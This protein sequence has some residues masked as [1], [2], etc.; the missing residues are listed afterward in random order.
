MDPAF[1]LA[2]QQS[3]V[4]VP[5]SDGFLD[6][7]VAESL[8]VPARVWQQMLR[9]LL[10]EDHSDRLRDIAVPS[11]IIWGDQDAFT[12]RSEQHLLLNLIPEARLSIYPGIGHAPHWEDT[13]R[14]SADIAAFI[15]GE[16]ALAA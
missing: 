9:A 13:P 11:L 1:A 8:K 3:S 16:N 4:A 6:N 5:L 2:F 15:A 10:V 14:A 12:G 7:V